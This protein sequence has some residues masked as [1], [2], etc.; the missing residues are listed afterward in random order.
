MKNILTVLLIIF[1]VIPAISSAETLQ[2][3][4]KRTIPV[5][6][7]GV[8]IL[9]NTNGAVE[10]EGWD[11]K[12]VIIE[13]QKIVRGGSSSTVETYFRKTRINVRKEG[14]NVIIRTIM[15]KR[16]FSFW[17]MIFGGAVNISVKYRLK[18]PYSITAKIKTTNGSI[19]ATHLKGVV[20]LSTTNG[21]ID[22]QETTGLVKAKTTN[23]SIR[24][25]LAQLQPD[26]EYEMQT[27]NG[28]IKI[29]LPANAMFEVHAQ[30]TNGSIESDFPV[31]VKGRLTGNAM[32][33]VVGDGGPVFLLQTTNGSITLR[34]R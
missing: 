31:K 11:G 25:E 33:G 9:E 24:A 28:S 34:A 2:K 7:D 16:H 14:K 12:E 29:W 10:I 3:T 17:K 1:I 23:G 15:P 8:V 21:K 4:I 13:A 27:T 22:I 6:P 19:T 5:S 20:M 32:E 18:I 26:G 30:T